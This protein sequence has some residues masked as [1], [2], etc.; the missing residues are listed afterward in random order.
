MR[1][2]SDLLLRCQSSINA[3]KDREIVIRGYKIAIIENISVLQVL[4]LL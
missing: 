4:I 1:L 3:A 2:T